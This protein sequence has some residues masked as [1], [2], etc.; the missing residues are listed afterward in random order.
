LYVGERIFC[1]SKRDREERRDGGRGEE[2][3]RGERELACVYYLSRDF[4][5]EDG[6]AFVDLNDGGKGRREGGG[7]QRGAER[8]EGGEEGDEELTTISP[9]HRFHPPQGRNAIHR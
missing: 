8:R 2:G 5:E 9:P 4:G 1:S 7:E 6:G 3:R